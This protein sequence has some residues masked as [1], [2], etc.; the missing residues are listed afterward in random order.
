MKKYKFHDA[1]DGYLN[2]CQLSNKD[3]L[4][5]ALDLGF[6]PL[7]DSLLTREELNKPETYYP[8]KLMRSKS[9][10]HSQLNYIVPGEIVYHMNY[11]YKC[12]ITAEVVKHHEEQA[13]INIEKLKIKKNSLVVDVGSNDGTLL[14]E[15]KKLGM[16][17]LGV[18]PT[19]I[20]KIAKKKGIDTIQ[21]VLNES[22]AKKIIKYKGK[23]KLVTATNVFAHMSSLGT[24][25]RAIQNLLENNGYF[26]FENHMV[27]ILKHNQY[28]TIYHE[29]IR[30][31]SL[32]SLIYL[33]SHLKVIYCKVLDI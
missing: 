30:N 3:D 32:K 26:I 27:D 20:A 14:N 16:S 13:K 10:G 22:V 9:L 5:E 19:N 12:G 25:M 8:L 6:Q 18:E 15:Y 17:V 28:D 31:Y 11:P 24:V 29:H 2:K 4:I 21:S 23:A 1:K 7:G 33:F